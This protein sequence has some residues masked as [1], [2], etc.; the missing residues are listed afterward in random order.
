MCRDSLIIDALDHQLAH[1][2]V[3]ALD[4]PTV[5]APTCTSMIIID[6]LDHQLAHLIHDQL[7][8]HRM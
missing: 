4:A 2:Q 6:A 5:G 7:A 3:G 1:H 8:H